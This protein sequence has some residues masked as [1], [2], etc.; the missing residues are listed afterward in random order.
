M[1][2]PDVGPQPVGFS[3]VCPGFVA[4]TGMYARWEDK[5]AKAQRMVGRSTP[6]KVAQVAGRCIHQNRGE[7][8]VNTS[9]VPPLIVL[10]NIAPRIVPRTM[11][12]L[13]YTRTFEP[14]TEH[15][16]SGAEPTSDDGCL[17]PKVDSGDFA[18]PIAS[19]HDLPGSFNGRT[20]VFGAVYRG[21]NPL[22]GTQ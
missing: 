8:L 6:G 18:L 10:F 2:D 12:L 11:K 13:G 14:V 9:P 4:E 1:T 19:G 15:T 5:G 17:V 20:S 16:G 3:V 21:S 7:A 22:P